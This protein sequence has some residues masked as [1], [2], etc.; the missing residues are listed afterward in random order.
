MF[1]PKTEWVCNIG[2]NMSSHR[3]LSTEQWTVLVRGLNKEYNKESS[4]P[5]ILLFFY[6][7]QKRYNYKK[8]SWMKLKIW[9]SEQ[10]QQN[11]LFTIIFKSSE[12]YRVLLIFSVLV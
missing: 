12:A 1:R 4:P 7:T 6:S 5:S 8:E 2:L 3:T 11:E 9:I 10:I